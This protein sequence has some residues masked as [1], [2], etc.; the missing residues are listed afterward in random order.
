MQ[1]RPNYSIVYQFR[2]VLKLEKQ[3]VE[4]KQDFVKHIKEV[5]QTWKDGDYFLRCSKGTFCYMTLN[6]RRVSLMKKSKATGKEY[7]CWEYFCAP[8][9]NLKKKVV[10]KK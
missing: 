3:N 4:T 6:G 1:V 10:K 5:T 2:P 8:N 7:L 9:G